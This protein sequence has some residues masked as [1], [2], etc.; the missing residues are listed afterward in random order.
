MSTVVVSIAILWAVVGL[1]T[2]SYLHRKKRAKKKLVCPLH[3]SC[4]KVI[5]S[6][7]ATTFGVP[8]ELLGIAYYI[9]LGLLYSLVLAL[10]MFFATPLVFA[11]IAAMT[12]GGVF[13][14]VY[15]IFIQ[16]ALLHAWCSWCLLSALSN[17]AL[18]VCAI[19]LR[20]IS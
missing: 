14:S 17:V 13:F 19:V 7:H 6:T 10:P 8:N 11:V 2:S 12:L 20:L 4:E 18:L 5:H 3:A 16:I 15:L 1:G 9:I